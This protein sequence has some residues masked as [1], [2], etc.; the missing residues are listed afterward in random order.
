[1]RR[2]LWW[3]E[4]WVFAPAGGVFAIRR[5]GLLAVFSGLLASLFDCLPTALAFPCVLS[6]LLASPLCLFA[7]G[8]GLS[9]YS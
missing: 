4:V 3:F 9:L 6:G 5:W 2:R 8:V 7:Y 1:V